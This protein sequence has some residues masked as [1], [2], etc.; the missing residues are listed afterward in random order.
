MSVQKLSHQESAI[1]IVGKFAEQLAERVKP[2]ETSITD[3]IANE[4]RGIDFF[5]RLQGRLSGVRQIKETL[6]SPG[7]FS[8]QSHFNEYYRKR[9]TRIFV[10]N[11]QQV[12][13]S[14]R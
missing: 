6:I 14:K 3:I 12:I 13:S 10:E 11:I 9:M 7:F 1:L 4:F 5:E 2:G 8:S